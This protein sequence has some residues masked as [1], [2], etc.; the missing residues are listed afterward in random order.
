MIL[1]PPF[2]ILRI[3]CK[4]LIVKEQTSSNVL[5]MDAQA[6]KESRYNFIIGCANSTKEY[7]KFS[8]HQ[9]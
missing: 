9:L 6:R 1:K 8:K 7:R 3:L 4:E 2:M 5:V